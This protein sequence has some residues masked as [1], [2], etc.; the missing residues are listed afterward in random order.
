VSKLLLLLP[1]ATFLAYSQATTTDLNSSD[2]ITNS[3]AV[4]NANFNSLKNALNSHTANTSNPHSTTATQTGA[5]DLS[6]N[7]ALGAHYFDMTNI[8]APSNP[9]S[10]VMRFYFKTGSG[11]CQK[12]SSGTETCFGPAGA[13]AVSQV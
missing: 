13:E 10:G 5:F 8:S 6:A 12:D 9:G 3:R 7:N 2:Y 4:I 11:L 1:F